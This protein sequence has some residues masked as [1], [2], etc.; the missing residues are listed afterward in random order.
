QVAAALNQVHSP[1]PFPPYEKQ[2]PVFM[3]NRDDFSPNSEL[4]KWMDSADGDAVAAFLN[5]LRA[6]GFRELSGGAI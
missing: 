6:R 3:T 1:Q 2:V 4:K 5:W